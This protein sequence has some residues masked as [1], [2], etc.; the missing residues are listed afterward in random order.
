MTDIYAKPIVNGVL[1]IVEQGGIRLGTLHRRENNHYMFS[2]KH[3]E[4]FFNKKSDLTKQFGKEF[5]IK[6]FDKDSV[7]ID[8]LEC[9]GYPTK[10]KPFK[11]IFNVKKKLPL[12]T[13]SDKSKSLF[14]AG[15][16]V[17][18]FPKNWIRTFCPKLITI[19]RY[20][21][22]GPF[23]TEEEAKG[24]LTNVK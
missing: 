24:I 18:K 7:E 3:G 4:L 10:W 9:H 6:N 13:K 1:W 17:V 11:C 2:T 21:Y 20:P 5:F 8:S 14:C 12:F 15:Y 22:H 19:E 23:K 16:Y